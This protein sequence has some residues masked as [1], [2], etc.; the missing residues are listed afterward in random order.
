[1]HFTEGCADFS[2]TKTRIFV[3]KTKILQI[4]QN[5]LN[6]GANIVSNLTL[7]DLLLGMSYFQ[8]KNTRFRT[9]CDIAL[10]SAFK[11]AS[12][13]IS[14]MRASMGNVNFQGNCVLLHKNKIAM[15]TS[16]LGYLLKSTL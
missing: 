10:Q 16:V 3:R 6:A 12:W 7:M 8:K 2:V 4:P 13:S 9:F 11:V 14:E 15:N 1:M 5:N